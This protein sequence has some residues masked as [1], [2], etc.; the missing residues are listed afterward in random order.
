MSVIS[1]GDR[2]RRRDHRDF[3][4]HPH[5]EPDNFK[6]GGKCHQYT[7]PRDTIGL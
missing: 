7:T 6:N 2:R 1:H 3:V 5:E 4:R